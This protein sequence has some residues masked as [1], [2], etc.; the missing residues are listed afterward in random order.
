M[1]CCRDGE[2]EIAESGSVR[3]ERSFKGIVLRGK[4]TVGFIER[5][6]SRHKVVI[7]NIDARASFFD[8]A[9]FLRG[10]SASDREA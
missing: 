5:E 6:S 7:E 8:R 1:N 3:R 2:V 9:V 4:N 10:T